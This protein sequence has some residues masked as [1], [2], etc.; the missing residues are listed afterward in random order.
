MRFFFSLL[1]A[2]KSGLWK[3]GLAGTLDKLSVLTVTAVS[4]AAAEALPACSCAPSATL[5]E[6]F[7]AASACAP[8]SAA[9]VAC[10][11]AA[12]TSTALTS[13]S[14]STGIAK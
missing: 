1:K 3:S 6:A 2:A 14:A 12:L 9:F 5:E 11:C 4:V 8:T 7:F 13:K 10:S